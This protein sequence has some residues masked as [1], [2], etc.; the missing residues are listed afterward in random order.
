MLVPQLCPASVLD[1]PKA[2]T[3]PQPFPDAGLSEIVQANPRNQLPT[4]PLSS[5]SS[6][7][8]AVGLGNLGRA[9]TLCLPPLADSRMRC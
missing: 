1:C 3:S 7:N 5:L 2:F 8:V 9:L 6:E 4:A